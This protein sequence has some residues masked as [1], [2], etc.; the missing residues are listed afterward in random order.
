MQVI[1]YLKIFKFNFFR[2]GKTFLKGIY[3]DCNKDITVH[4]MTESV[5]LYREFGSNCK[6]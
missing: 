5:N 4:K 1:G 2:C 6:F 3:Y